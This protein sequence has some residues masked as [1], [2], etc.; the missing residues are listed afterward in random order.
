VAIETI[1]ILDSSGVARQVYA[2]QIGAA[3]AQVFKLGWGSD[4]VLT[5]VD[6][7]N[8]LPV[9][10]PNL[11]GLASEA[12]LAALLPELAQ[13]LEPGD[14]AAL[15]TAA[16][17]DAAKTALD[18]LHTDLSGTLKVKDSGTFGYRAGSAAAAVDVPT[19]ARIKRV[20]VLAGAAVAGTVQI[21][22]GDVITIPAGGSFDEQL[23]GDAVATGSTTE[24]VI[25]GTVQAFYVSWTV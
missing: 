22:G 17:Q 7:S 11:A 8:P 20:S 16:K 25:G 23:P 9:T 4:G 19:G 12:T 2:D 10:L 21:L 14:L 24:V 18:L 3:F 13:K 1:T 15:A 5:L 6:G